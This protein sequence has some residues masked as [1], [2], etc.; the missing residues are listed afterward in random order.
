MGFTLN[1]TFAAASADISTY[2][3]LQNSYGP[4]NYETG[5]DQALAVTAFANGAAGSATLQ[6][7][8]VDKAA[9]NS[10]SSSA[11]AVV[12]MEEAAV[13]ITARRTGPANTAGNYVCTVTFTVSNR[14]CVDLITCPSGATASGAEYE[15]RLGCTA[16]TTIT[17]LTVLGVPSGIV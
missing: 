2:A 17:S 8:L 15:F 5:K 7:V 14:N 16:L 13:A 9:L 11:D 4:S 12:W 6:L 3:T 10:G 1:K